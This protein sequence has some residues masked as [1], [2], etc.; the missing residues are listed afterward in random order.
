MLR[1]TKNGIHRLER[2]SIVIRKGRVNEAR[3]VKGDVLLVACVNEIVPTSFF[4]SGV[5]VLH[6]ILTFFDQRFLTPLHRTRDLHSTTAGETNE[7]TDNKEYLYLCTVQ[8]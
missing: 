8:M 1:V 6:V 4:L 7:R 3:H 5:G 2:F